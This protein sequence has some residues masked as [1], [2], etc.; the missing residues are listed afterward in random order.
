MSGN[1]TAGDRVIVYHGN[2]NEANAKLFIDALHDQGI[3]VVAQLLPAQLPAGPP[4]VVAVIQSAEDPDDAYM[5]QYGRTRRGV[6]LDSLI[7]DEAT[8]PQSR[9]DCPRAD[10]HHPHTWTAPSTLGFGVALAY[11]KGIPS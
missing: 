1:L 7:V 11:C 5:C 3:E 2:L 10:S 6:P 9:G 8:P 4:M